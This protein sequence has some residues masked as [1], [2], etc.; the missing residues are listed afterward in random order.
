MSKPI[1]DVTEHQDGTRVRV[2]CGSAEVWI[3]AT[4]GGRRLSIA[5]EEGE[6]EV[7]VEWSIRLSDEKRRQ[8]VMAGPFVQ[9]P[10]RDHWGEMTARL[11]QEVGN[12]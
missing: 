6:G 5:V 12:G 3:R 2:A 7:D 11:R 8:P 10:Y 4:P 9:S 1:I